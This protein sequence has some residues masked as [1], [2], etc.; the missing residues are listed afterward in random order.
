[1]KVIVFG[2]NGQLGS[3]IGRLKGDLDI[4]LLDREDVDLTDSHLLVSALREMEFDILINAAAYTAVD[5]AESEREMADLINSVAPGLM[6]QDCVEKGAK[7]IHISTDYVFNGESTIPLVEEMIIDPIN[8]YGLSK[9]KGEEAV[10][11]TLTE[12]VI[13]RTSWLYGKGGMNFPNTMLR[14]AET[15]DEINVVY[16]Q[17]GN[18]TNA[19]DLAQLI[20]LLCRSELTDKYGTYHYSNEGVCSWYDFA[21]AVFRQK[22]LR[23]KVNPVTSEMFPTPAKRPSYSV[24][25]KKK[26]KDTFG[27][28]IRHWYDALADYLDTENR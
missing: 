25:N 6:A 20:V 2:K 10:R 13:L 4:S 18:P 1:M 9:W 21:L 14:L 7:M 26:I 15:R 22:N 27:V 5:K 17:V 16:D 28:K 8:H 19:A 11:T 24:L 3:E 12:H 23:L